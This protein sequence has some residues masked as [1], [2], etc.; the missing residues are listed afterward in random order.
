VAE[1]TL[2]RPKRPGAY[3]AVIALSALILAA[4]VVGSWS[5]AR[6]MDPEV[7]ALIRTR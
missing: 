3:A 1:R 4:G 2:R 6:H 5:L 7:G